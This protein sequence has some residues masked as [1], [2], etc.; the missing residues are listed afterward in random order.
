MGGDV[1]RGV[2][3]GMVV[4]KFLVGTCLGAPADSNGHLGCGRALQIGEFLF[5]ALR[6]TR[7]GAPLRRWRSRASARRTRAGSVSPGRRLRT[8]RGA[9]TPRPT[10]GAARVAAAPGSGGRTRVGYGG[11]PR[12]G[13]F[14]A[15]R[16]GS[17][18]WWG[19]EGRSAHCPPSP[20]TRAWFEACAPHPLAQDLPQLRCGEG[21][22][23]PAVELGE[24]AAHLL[25]AQRGRV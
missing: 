15:A 2:V 17:V 4:G 22:V 18:D 9:R 23:A 24:E 12:N 11:V 10:S 20:K 21:A 13:W 25:R 7:S 19:A 8:A 14:M 3:N 6:P 5:L 16:S 1:V